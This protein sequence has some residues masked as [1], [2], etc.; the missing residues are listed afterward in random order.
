MRINIKLSWKKT[1]LR[2]AVIAGIAAAAVF[3]YHLTDNWDF[4]RRSGAAGSEASA[5]E[6]K[7]W[8]CAAALWA[9]Y[10][11]YSEN[12]SAVFKSLEAKNEFNG[13]R[14]LPEKAKLQ[15]LS[16]DYARRLR[17]HKQ[18]LVKLADDS[19]VGYRHDVLMLH[20]FLVRLADLNQLRADFQINAEEHFRK[21]F[22]S[23][24]HDKFYG[25]Y[26]KSAADSFYIY[27]DQ[28]FQVFETKNIFDSANMV[29]WKCGIEHGGYELYQGISRETVLEEFAGLKDSWLSGS[30]KAFRIALYEADSVCLHRRVK[31]GSGFAVLASR[32]NSWHNYIF[33]LDAIHYLNKHDV[34]NNDILL[35]GFN[36]FLRF[37]HLADEKIWRLA[38]YLCLSTDNFLWTVKHST[39]PPGKQNKILKYCIRPKY[40]T[41]GPEMKFYGDDLKA[42]QDYCLERSG[43]SEKMLKDNSGTEMGNDLLR[44]LSASRTIGETWRSYSAGTIDYKTYCANIR[45]AEEHFEMERQAIFRKHWIH[46]SSLSQG[47]IWTNAKV[48]DD[49]VLAVP[50]HFEGMNY[51]SR[52]RLLAEKQKQ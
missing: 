1:V 42:A 27:P 22:D 36:P 2:I 52:K 46:I 37:S 29:F 34:L 8:R 35:S 3:I 13:R 41:N 40:D 32:L 38:E 7:L 11:A 45:Q 12:N 28:E 4:A 17:E 51:A 19:D 15:S 14:R 5:E 25:L 21:P 50:I 24:L 26:I 16:R 39:V 20:A 49:G 48:Y 30:P 6:E 18:R 10:C 43:L 44:L 9:D 33:N 23:D 31:N 47:S